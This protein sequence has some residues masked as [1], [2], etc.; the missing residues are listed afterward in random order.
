MFKRHGSANNARKK[1]EDAGH[2]V[3]LYDAER[4]YA[5]AGFVEEDDE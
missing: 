4:M 3:T 2:L 1:A 5:S